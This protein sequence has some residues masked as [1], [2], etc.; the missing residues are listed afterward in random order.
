MNGT[1]DEDSPLAIDDNSFSIICNT[2]M[3][4]L[5]TKKEDR[6]E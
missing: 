5:R 4:K 1:R 6:E 2:T 3:N